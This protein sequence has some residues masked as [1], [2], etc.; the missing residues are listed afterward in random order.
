M[1]DEEMVTEAEISDAEAVEEEVV[2]ETEEE[3]EETESEEDETVSET[4]EEDDTSNDEQKIHQRKIAELAYKERELKRQNARLMQMLEKQSEKVGKTEA[5]KIENY[6]TFDEYLDARDAWKAEQ[7]QPKPDNQ[8][9]DMA[10]FELGRDELYANGIAKHPDFM[11]V[12]GAEHVDIS[13]PMAQA[14]IELGD[15][16]LSVDTAYYLGSNPKE[17]SRIAKLSPIKQMAEVAK[18]SVKISSRKSPT[19]QPT[20]A[21]APVKPVKSKKTTTSEIREEMDFEAFM[22]ARNKQLGRA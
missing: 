4:D 22:K 14:I 13:F 2:E 10:E 11:E 5:P 8:A 1:S 3:V 7:S 18:L 6:E 15:D 19:K 17:A 16:D 21:P 12:V 9:Y 20:K